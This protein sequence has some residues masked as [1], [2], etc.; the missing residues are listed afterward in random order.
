MIK[1]EEKEKIETPLFA[2]SEQIKQLYSEDAAL[3]QNLSKIDFSDELKLGIIPSES[4]KTF[5]ATQTYSYS[6]INLFNQC[7]FKWYMQYI[8]GFKEPDKD[9]FQTGKICHKVAEWSGEWCYKEL[10]KNKLL[11]YMKLKNKLFQVTMK[12]NY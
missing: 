8:K 1:S 6:R 11:A 5:L 9:Y 2:T 7:P 4:D 12:K 3:A 10:F